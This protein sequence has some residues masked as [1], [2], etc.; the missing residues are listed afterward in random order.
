[1]HTKSQHDVISVRKSHEQAAV[2]AWDMIKKA[3]SAKGTAKLESEG[4]IRFSPEVS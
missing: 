4:F 2:E 3:F 1:M